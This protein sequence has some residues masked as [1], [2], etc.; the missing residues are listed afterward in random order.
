MG[1]LDDVKDKIRNKSLK[2]KAGGTQRKKR[3]CNINQAKS[4]GILYEA[5]QMVSF[6]IVKDLV[7]SLTRKDLKISALGYVDSKHLIDH[8]LYR[9]GFTFISKNNLNWYGKPVS[10]NV[11]E[12]V[13]IPFDILINLSLDYSYPIQYITALSK[14]SFKVGIFS[15][16]QE[17]LDMMI[18]LEKEKKNIENVKN[19]IR[20]NKKK[21]NNK[22]L[23]EEKKKEKAKQEK[24]IEKKVETEMQMNFLISQLLH[25]LS[26]V[27]N[28]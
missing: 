9:K 19:E 25:Y 22:G 4:V 10:E 3:V 18:D 20:K 28:N 23:T 13:S 15:P 5:T 14:A 11:D 7:K 27:K 1:T 26:I 2:K 17:F 21:N 6:E 16:G 12:F 24:E 8:Y